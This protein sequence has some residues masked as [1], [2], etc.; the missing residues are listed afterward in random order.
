MVLAG[1][2]DPVYQVYQT[3]K[4]YQTNS[5]TNKNKHNHK[6]KHNHSKPIFF[7]DPVRSHQ[8]QQPQDKKS[9]DPAITVEENNEIR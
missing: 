1:G 7:L 8:I 5:I 6:H 4:S 9:P 2:Y 3:T